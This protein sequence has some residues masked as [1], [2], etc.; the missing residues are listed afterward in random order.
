M[1]C[2]AQE[3]INKFA[4]SADSLASLKFRQPNQV[5][6]WRSDSLPDG[7]IK[8]RPTAINVAQFWVHR[9]EQQMLNLSESESRRC[10]QSIGISTDMLRQCN[11]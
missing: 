10:R 11:N 9:R 8:N 2:G 4:A 6:C 3:T 1:E 7:P 5:G